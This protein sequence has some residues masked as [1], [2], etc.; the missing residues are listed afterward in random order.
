MEIKRVDPFDTEAVAAW[1]AAWAAGAGAGR[2]D[3]PIW[4]V[5]E[6]TATLRDDNP[7]RSLI[8]NAFAAVED[9]VVVGAADMQYPTKDN[10]TLVEM[11]IDVPPEHRGRGVG[12]A[13]FEHLAAQA[14]ELGRTNIMTS[15]NQPIGAP[16]VPGVAFATRHGFTRR[17]V[18]LRRVL[19]LPVPASILDELAAEAEPHLGGYRVE[20]WVG[21]CPDRYAEQYA[22]LKSLLM[23]QAPIGD[24]DYEPEVWNVE[25]LRADEALT[26]KQDR[27]LLTAIAVAP[28]GSLAGHTQLAVPTHDPRTYQWDTL[29]LP[30]HRGHRLGLALK[31][32]NLRVLCEN[33]PDRKTNL[34]WNA[35]QNGPMNAVNEK[36]GFRAVER[37]EEWQRS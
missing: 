5:P 28:D 12:S 23:S 16:E 29:V 17:N 30:K 33:F 37:L 11:E 26:A 21:P 22:H 10:P 36:L 27:T 24:M 31:V 20:T 32:A 35:E 2:E 1:H 3:P 14:A 13:L 8:W 4:T 25:R 15:V 6:I 18:E 19:D 7:D 34:T 9:G